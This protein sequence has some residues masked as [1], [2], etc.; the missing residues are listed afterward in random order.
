[1]LDRATASVRFLSG[2]REP[3]RVATTANIALDGLQTIDGVA[4][5]VNDRVLVKDQTDQRLN[6]IYTAS[7]GLW[8]RASDARFPR[9]IA[10]GVTVHVQDGAVHG[11]QAFRF[12]ETPEKIG[13][14]NII[15]DFYLSANFEEDAEAALNVYK[16]EFLEYANET[17]T[18][19]IAP[20]VAQAGGF[21]DAAAQSAQE[22]LAIAGSYEDLQ[23]AVDL[24]DLHAQEAANQVASVIPSVQRFAVGSAVQSVDLGNVE[25]HPA[26]VRVFIDGVY[27]FG[28]AWSLTD[29]V[30]TP[31]GG[32]WPGDGIVENMEVVIDATSAIAF[33]V[34]SNGSVT[35]PRLANGAVTLEKLD[36]DIRLDDTRTFSTDLPFGRAGIRVL[37]GEKYD[38]HYGLPSSVI[39]YPS[40]KS[41]FIYRRAAG[42][43]ITDGAEV[44]AADSYDGGATL[45]N[46]RLIYSNPAHDAR[47][48][49]GR[50]FANGKSGF[51]VNRQDEGTVHFSP[52]LIHSDDEF[53][54]WTEQTIT[55]SS[56]YTFSSTGGIID[57]PASQGGHDTEGFIAFGFAAAGVYSAIS[58]SDNWAT[59]TVHPNIATL[60]TPSGGTA[61]TALSEWGGARIGN[62]DK[63]IFYLRS[64]D[65]GGWRQEAACYVTTNLLSWG[66]PVRSNLNLGG[67]PPCCFFDEETNQFHFIGFGRGGRPI[68]QFE[69][70]M[71]IASADGDELWAANGNWAALPTPVS[72]RVVTPLPNWSTGYMAPVKIGDKWTATFAAGEP[73]SA[74]GDRSVLLMIGDFVPSMTD[75]FKLMESFNTNAIFKYL[76][77]GFAAAV[78]PPAGAYIDAA[79][80]SANAGFQSYNGGTTSRQHYRVVNANGY[81][82]GIDGAGSATSFLTSSDGQLK[83]VESRVALAVELDIGA[84]IDGLEPVAYD[85]LNTRGEPTGERGYGLIAQDVKALIPSAVSEG[86]GSPG[87][88]DYKP[89]SMDNSKL[90][91][92]L[93][94]ELKSVR[95]R[96]NAL[97]GG[98]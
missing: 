49:A 84:I 23:E 93:L 66:A 42:H 35:T 95:A 44:R 26:A 60:G 71:L 15:I 21:A 81:I 40:G 94:A 39:H 55:L 73:G 10:E 74:G 61:V 67:N 14:S 54:T 53:E 59:Y 48:D 38:A 92:F 25:L 6:G 28:N 72:W 31:V 50:I 43:A 68:D 47:P 89:W 51:M 80:D 57:F 19:V 37:R 20:L 82:G 12:R 97:E 13:V 41:V 7:R 58:T 91:V 98:E 32:S 52:L 62:Q 46:D 96:L 22:A 11:G 2:E 63:W 9:A 1:M 3:V 83:P 76:R 75:V 78:N 70:H 18:E 4:L 65:S 86:H 77:A 69:H 45:V 88:D 64:Q 79:V 16:A 5:A 87:D 33:M 24:A 17:S 27:Q 56:P 30:I 29:G 34:P 8:Y 85:W 36:P 90:V